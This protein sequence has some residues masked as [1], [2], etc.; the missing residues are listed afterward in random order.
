MSNGSSQ[1]V[2]DL[3]ESLRPILTYTLIIGTFALL[4]LMPANKWIGEIM[5]LTTLAVT[6]WFGS[7]PV[8]RK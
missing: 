2:R 6:F 7:R 1:W 5:F 4:S 3:R 8:S